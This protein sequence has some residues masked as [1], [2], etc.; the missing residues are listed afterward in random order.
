MFQRASGILLHPT[1][2]PSRFGIG[3]LGRSTYEFVDFLARSGQKLWQILPLAPTGYEHSPYTMNFSVF[4][5]NPLLISLDRL[6]E[7]GLLN[8]EELTPLENVP[9]D[10]VEFNRVIPHKMRLLRIAYDRFQKSQSSDFSDFCEQQSEWL[11]DFSLFMALLEA[12]EGKNWN[13]WDRAIAQRKPEA[14]EGATQALQDQIRFHQF[15]QF[16]F[17]EQWLKL[18]EYT[19]RN[20]SV[21][22]NM[23]VGEQVLLAMAEA[24]QANENLEFCDRLL[25]ALEAGEAAGGDK[26]GRQS[27]ALYSFRAIACVYHGRID[28]IKQ[29][30][31]DTGTRAANLYP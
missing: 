3:D 22:G 30:E 15:L 21:A 17:F 4:A 9:T 13:Q 28:R 26:R 10:R 20:F 31:H 27:A 24:Y 25:C 14:L 18:R 5:G 2:F 7:E 8:T 12:N 16:K 1:C 29:W 11:D 23:L 6:A 19:F